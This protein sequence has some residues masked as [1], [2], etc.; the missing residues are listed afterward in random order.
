[1]L[2]YYFLE[3]YILLI[4]ISMDQCF[5]LPEKKKVNPRQ[6][7]KFCPRIFQTG[8]E[9][10]LEDCPRKKI[11]P[12]KKTSKSNPRK[13]SPC[14]RKKIKLFP[15]KIEKIPWNSWISAREKNKFFPRKNFKLCPRKLQTARDF[16]FLSGR[17]KKIC[18]RKKPRKV[19]KNVF[20]GTFHF[21]G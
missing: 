20:S 14:P 12:E 1:M 21:L 16:F 8:R 9:K 13:K 6:I 3:Y 11:V 18:P 10:N 4:F 5:F 2:L 17:E 15:V 7:S 19:P